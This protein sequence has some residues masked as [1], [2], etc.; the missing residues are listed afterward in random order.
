MSLQLCVNQLI[1]EDP[2]NESPLKSTCNF[3]RMA[4]PQLKNFEGL[5]STEVSSVSRVI[6]I[7]IIAFIS[8]KV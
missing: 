4:L 6:Q 8:T 2:S 5:M 7:S 3:C 1:Q